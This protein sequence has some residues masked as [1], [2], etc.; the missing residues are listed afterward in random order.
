MSR[1]DPPFEPPQTG[2]GRFMPS[3][4]CSTCMFSG[5]FTEGQAHKQTQEHLAAQANADH[6]S[7]VLKA[8]WKCGR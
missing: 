6:R 4:Q 7:A 3:L 2:H 5:T 1:F 8:I